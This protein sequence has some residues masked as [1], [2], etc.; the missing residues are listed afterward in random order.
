MG[1]DTLY[2]IYKSLLLPLLW[3]TIFAQVLWSSAMAYWMRPP[4]SVLEKTGTTGDY[5]DGAFGQFVLEWIVNF[6]DVWVVKLVFFFGC[7][8]LSVRFL[9]SLDAHLDS[10]M[11]RAPMSRE[12]VPIGYV[13][14]WPII[15]AVP[16]TLLFVFW[17]IVLKTPWSPLWTIFLGV[18]AVVGFIASLVALSG[19]K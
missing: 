4:Q 18:A 1:V 11:Q 13:L 6:S 17:A 9:E 19:K 5:A 16:G 15:V 12:I 8:V 2:R 7:M 3:F 14:V 10:E